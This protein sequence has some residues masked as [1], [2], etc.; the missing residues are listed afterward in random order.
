[1]DVGE[2]CSDKLDDGNDTRPESDSSQ[3]VSEHPPDPSEDREIDLPLV[4][5]PV[6][7]HKGTSNGHFVTGKE[8]LG[9][10]VQAKQVVQPDP[11]NVIL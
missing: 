1:M 4:S 5:G 3:V 11:Q 7:L 8:E 6:E 9:T 2:D 10:P